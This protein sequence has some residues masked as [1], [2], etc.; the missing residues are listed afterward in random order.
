ME[1]PTHHR[2]GGVRWVKCTG[3]EPPG[4]A[5]PGDTNGGSFQSTDDLKTEV[6]KIAKGLSARGHTRRGEVGDAE[7]T[8]KE[9]C[10]RKEENPDKYDLLEPGEGVS[11]RRR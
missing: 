8:E 1:M 2:G 9:C 3:P 7:E 10:V 6:S 5:Q 11:G 4:S